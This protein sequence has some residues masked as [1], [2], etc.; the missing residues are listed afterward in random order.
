LYPPFICS[1]GIIKRAASFPVPKNMVNKGE[2]VSYEAMASYLK[3]SKHE[4]RMNVRTAAVG[5]SI[6]QAYVKKLVIPKMTRDQLLLNLPYE[7]KDYIP[8]S[9]DKLFYD[10]YIIDE[11][12]NEANVHYYN[13]MAS[14][15]AK[16]TAGQYETLLKR[17]GFKLCTLLPQE[18]AFGGIIREYEKLNPSEEIQDYCII[19]LGH[20]GTRVHLY[21]GNS[22]EVTRK[23]DIGGKELDF[24]IAQAKGVDELTAKMYKH[25]NYEDVQHLPECAVIYSNIAVE[26]MRAI[27]FYE[28]TSSNSN[29]KKA[30]VCGGGSKVGPLIRQIRK[31]ITVE[32]DAIVQLMPKTAK[33]IADPFLYSV[34]L[35]VTMQ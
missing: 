32:L 30:Y 33:N 11:I 20:E 7:L 14:A 27:N 10:Y 3:K 1:N 21:R 6:Q 24:A 23:I 29:L 17:S 22:F 31:N 9:S 28:F 5:M 26:I 34:A 35:G 13:I 12:Q 2:I 15:V 25:S 18:L 4:G 8:Q 19:D 16:D